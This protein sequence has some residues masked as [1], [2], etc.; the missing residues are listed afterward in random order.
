[1]LRKTAI[2]TGASSGIGRETALLFAR[3]GY[4]VVLAMH[5]TSTKSLEKEIKSMGVE[6]L[7]LE[8]DLEDEKKIESFFKTAF[9]KFEYVD[10]VV[11]CAGIALKQKLF[12]DTTSKE[13]DK[14]LNVNLRG[15]M[16]TNREAL[17]YL[18]SQKH[19]SIVNV[20][21]ILGETG[22]SFEAIY[23]SS[24][25]GIIALTKSLAVEV[26]PFKVRINAVAP[27][28]IDTKMTSNIIEENREDCLSQIPLGRFG[29]PIDVA[30]LIYF[31]CQ[32]TSSYITG[33]CIGANGGAIRFD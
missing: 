27:G 9:E 32:E 14:I 4:N 21:S 33:Q 10:C 22:G 5:S 2:I 30:N 25:G 28:F 15:T 19:G 3:N 23:S 16:L 24:K 7:S 12:I 17:K 26:S 20:S 31:L 29:K 8:F 1:M 6:A 18:T 11:S 13:M